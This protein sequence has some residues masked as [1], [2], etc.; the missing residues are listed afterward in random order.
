MGSAEEELKAIAVSQEWDLPG[1]P[2]LKS[3]LEVIDTMMNASTKS[4]SDNMKG[5]A[6][7]AAQ[8]TFVKLRKNF[9]D[10]Q[11][12]VTN[13]E[14]AIT[15]ANERREAAIKALES[16]P[17][18]EID[19][20]IANAAR[21]ASAVVFRGIT[22]PAD[23]AISVIQG[24][25][26]NEREEKAEAARNALKENLVAPTQQLSVSRQNLRIY[27]PVVP[28]VAPPEPYE[29]M[30]PVTPGTPGPTY[31]GPG[32]GGGGAG[33]SGSGTGT[34]VIVGGGLVP[35]GNPTIIPPVG[36]L[37]VDGNL[38]GV[39]TSVDCGPRPNLTPVGGN[40]GIGLGVLGGGGASAA[41]IAVGARLATGGTAGLGGGGRFGNAGSMFGGGSSSGP[42]GAGA[43]G[44]G[45]AGRPGGAGGVGGRPSV[46]GLLGSGAGGTP[47]AAG[48]A[49]SATG[50]GN[51]AAGGR[52]GT[53]MMGGNSGGAASEKE[54]RSGLGGPLAPKL[55]DEDEG[56][57]RSAAAGAGGRDNLSDE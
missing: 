20:A 21:T 26:G 45:G 33:G 12:E 10:L 54:K 47:T 39:D 31:P 34:A 1:T 50:S 23:T 16:L 24:M 38:V 40:T 14:S 46:G 57:P 18:A 49:S 56:R 32:G 35:H 30:A 37:T 3:A 27:E 5:S 44:A 51:A 28:G 22:L 48:S 13:I 15:L 19:P 4:L 25:L 43:G 55:E 36:V 6:S 2:A 42:G 29:P 17:G 7:T 52:S 53:G 8:A 9:Q 11:T 41:A